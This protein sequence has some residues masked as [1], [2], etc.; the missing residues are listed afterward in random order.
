MTSFLESHRPGEGPAGPFA[1]ESSNQGNLD[2]KEM[3]MESA[4]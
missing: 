4:S 1:Y 3:V 2:A